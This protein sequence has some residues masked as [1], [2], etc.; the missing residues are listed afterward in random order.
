VHTPTN[1]GTVQT[2]RD[3]WQKLPKTDENVKSRKIASGMPKDL[4]WF[5]EDCITG[6]SEMGTPSTTA[7]VHPYQFTTSMA[8]LAVEA[9]V[10]VIFG[11]VKAIEKD[12]NGVKSVT[13]ED[14]MSKTSHTIPATDVILAAGPWTKTV[15]P[16]APIQAMRAHSV[17]VKADVTPYAIFS[18]IDLPKDFG[19][20]SEGDV[21]KRKHELTV[22]PEMY[23]RPDGTVYACGSFS[24]RF[25]FLTLHQSL[26]ISLK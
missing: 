4:D 11:S 25:S 3:E 9:G 12:A 5:D 13:Y 19:M 18:E 14:K 2:K 6:Y 7:Q 1:G 10:N 22:S 16:D 8:D 20:T 24:L 21:K 15:F 23:A 17:V 26:L